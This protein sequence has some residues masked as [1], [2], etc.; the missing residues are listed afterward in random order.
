MNNSKFLIKKK[1]SPTLSYN[2]HFVFSILLVLGCKKNNLV[3]ENRR[4]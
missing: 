2:Y 1:F 3:D 4:M